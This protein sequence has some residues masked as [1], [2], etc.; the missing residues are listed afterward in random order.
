[1]F[2]DVVKEKNRMTKCCSDL[3]IIVLIKKFNVSRVD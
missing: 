3:R 1:M 2:V